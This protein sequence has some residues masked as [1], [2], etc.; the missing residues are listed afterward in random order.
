[1]WNY[2]LKGEQN[3]TKNVRVW[4][5]RGLKMI[6]APLSTWRYNCVINRLNQVMTPPINIIRCLN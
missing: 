3:P 2:H 4:V 1:M 6:D 5:K